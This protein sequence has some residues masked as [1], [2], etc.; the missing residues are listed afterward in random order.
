MNDGGMD[1]ETVTDTKVDLTGTKAAQILF[2]P[3]P[4]DTYRMLICLS[5][6]FTAV[7]VKCI[8]S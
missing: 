2:T 4:E 5:S 1:S 3:N 7:L 8:L 6:S